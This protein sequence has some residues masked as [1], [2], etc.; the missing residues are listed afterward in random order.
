[1]NDVGHRRSPEPTERHVCREH[2]RG[3]QHTLQHGQR[4][5]GAENHP[6]HVVHQKRVA[7]GTHD[8]LR[9]RRGPLTTHVPSVKAKL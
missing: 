5:E 2:D 1:M 4:G 3:D 6:D 9:S 8:N 7:V